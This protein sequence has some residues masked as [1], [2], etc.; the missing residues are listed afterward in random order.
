[1]LSL[2]VSRTSVPA[3]R[4]HRGA[5]ERRARGA[6]LSLQPRA[7]SAP[8]REQRPIRPTPL[9]PQRAAGAGVKPST[10]PARAPPR[11]AFSQS[12]ASP[13]PTHR[14]PAQGLSHP[15]A[16]RAMGRQVLLLLLQPH[17]AASGA[18]GLGSGAHRRAALRRD[19]IPLCALQ[20]AGGAG[21]GTLQGREA[22]ESQ[23]PL[24]GCVPHKHHRHCS[25]L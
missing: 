19:G 9:R 10:P 16:S 6:G 22:E 23:G 24:P 4:R 2:S 25:D 17:W 14:P 3:T 13:D 18:P 5:R 7:S 15:V 21:C 8:P 11:L 1:M 12:N 20:G